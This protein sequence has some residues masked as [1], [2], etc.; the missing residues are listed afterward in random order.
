VSATII[1]ALDKSRAVAQAAALVSLEVKDGHNK[2]PGK[3]CPLR[4]DCRHDAASRRA[5]DFSWVRPPICHVAVFFS[6][7]TILCNC[8]SILP[9]TLFKYASN[10]GSGIP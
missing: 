7:G 6:I 9:P 3:N 8:S 5:V 2:A 4:G 10:C 1:G